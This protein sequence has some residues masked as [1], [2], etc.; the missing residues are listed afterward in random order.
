MEEK[1]MFLLSLNSNKKWRWYFECA[2]GKCPLRSTDAIHSI[3]VCQSRNQWLRS[4]SNRIDSS[5]YQLVKYVIRRIIRSMLP[6]FASNASHVITVLLQQHAL[7]F[8]SNCELFYFFFCIFSLFIPSIYPFRFWFLL[9]GNAASWFHWIYSIK[10]RQTVN[11]DFLRNGRLKSRSTVFF[12]SFLF[13]FA[14]GK[15][16]L[17]IYLSC[18]CFEDNAAYSHTTHDGIAAS[19][20]VRA[21]HCHVY[22]TRMEKVLRLPL[23]FGGAIRVWIGIARVCCACEHCYAGLPFVQSVH[24]VVCRYLFSCC[25]CCLNSTC[26]RVPLDKNAFA[27]ENETV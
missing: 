10:V 21:P 17:S 19:E 27:N 5:I 12:S 3:H 20:S 23:P 4:F 9:R 7:I 24:S 22:C 18:K 25:L 15:D 11:I 14:F 13:L 8:A 16:P 26:F 1:L 6:S 2:F